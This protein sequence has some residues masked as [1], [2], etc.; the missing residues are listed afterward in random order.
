[1]TVAANVAPAQGTPEWLD[2]RLG[3]YGASDAPILVAGDHEAWWR[4]HARK[5]R[6]IDAGGGERT[7]SMKWGLLLEDAIAQA[8]TDAHPEHPKVVSV[9][10]P[11]MHPERPHVRASLDR[12]RKRGRVVVELKKWGWPTDDFGPSGTDQVPEG[13]IDQV[14]QQLAVTGYDQVDIAVLFA[15]GSGR[16]PFR[17]YSIGRD[18]SRIDAILTL[19]DSAWAYVARGEMPP[20]PGPAPTRLRIRDGELEADAELVELIARGH[21]ARLNK[22]Q[23]EK[24]DK[25]LTAEILERIGAWSVVR[26]ESID[27][28]AKPNKDGTEIGWEYIATAY[29]RTIAEARRADDLIAM[30]RRLEAIDLDAVEAMFT[31][32]KAGSRPL[33]YVPHKEDPNAE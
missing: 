12:K 24:A 25:A 17:W 29:R 6:L 32:T 11:L 31:R 30:E 23:A 5:L 19:E 7:D 18:Q 3:G 4:L 9:K 26:G 21:Q 15:G 14:Q 28:T 8:Y 16:D 13:W 1:M 20:Y 10:R 22:Q 2:W 33:R 27:I